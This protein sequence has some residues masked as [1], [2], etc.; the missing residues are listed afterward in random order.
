MNFYRIHAAGES[1]ET[2]LNASRKDGWVADDESAESQ[3]RGISCCETEDDMRTYI[4]MYSMCINKGD[5]LVRLSGS[6]SQ[7][8]DRDQHAV[9]AIVS[10]YEV[11][12]DAG[13]WLS[14]N[15]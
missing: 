6:L 15:I 8:A 7:D 14:S 12:G 5:T 3:P 2:L 11:M 1:L 10:S 13:K 9:R 4:R